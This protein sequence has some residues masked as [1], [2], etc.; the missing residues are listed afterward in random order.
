MDYREANRGYITPSKLKLFIDSPL[1][2]KAIYV[3]EV[4][5]SM[6]KKSPALEL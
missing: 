6:L 2:Y 3:D 1:L 4:D 5:I